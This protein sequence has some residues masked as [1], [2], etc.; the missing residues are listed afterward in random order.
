MGQIT[1]R[2]LATLLPLMGTHLT[3]HVPPEVP[4][5]SKLTPAMSKLEQSGYILESEL[6]Q[7]KLNR[8]ALQV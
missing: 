2:N 1:I 8:F 4:R 3:R 5:M 6:A 7:I